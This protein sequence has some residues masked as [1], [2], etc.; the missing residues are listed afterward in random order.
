MSEARPLITFSHI[1]YSQR[2]LRCGRAE[3]APAAD[4]KARRRLLERS[5][6]FFVLINRHFASLSSSRCTFLLVLHCWERPMILRSGKSKK[7]H[8]S[9]GKNKPPRNPGKYKKA[10]R[11][12]Q[13]TPQLRLPRSPAFHRACAARSLA[14]SAHPRRRARSETRAAALMPALMHRQGGSRMTAERREKRGPPRA[15]SE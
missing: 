7:P 2:A 15:H 13:T 12:I 11:K 9:N 3:A 5:L 8:G 4:D 10:A 1:E 6:L 14:Q